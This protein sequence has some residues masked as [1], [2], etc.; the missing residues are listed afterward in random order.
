MRSLLPAFL[1]STVLVTVAALLM[2]VFDGTGSAIGFMKV[3]VRNDTARTVKV[4]PCWDPA[5]FETIDLHEAIIPP[6]KARRVTGEWPNDITE[7]VVVGVSA[8]SAETLHVT[9]CVFQYF[10]AGTHTGVVRVSSQGICPT[11]GGGGGGG[12]G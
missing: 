10:P 7:L 5:C 11:G 8:P 3:W 9:G 2:F 4:M 1:I 12:G 6:G